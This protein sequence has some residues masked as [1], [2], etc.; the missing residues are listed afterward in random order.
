MGDPYRA[1][2][3][4]YPQ[5]A[6]SIQQHDQQS[7]HLPLSTNPSAPE[8]SLRD[9]PPADA[10]ILL[11]H[12][13]D[14]VVTQ[15]SSLPPGE[16]PHWTILNVR[17]AV[18][19]LSNITY[20]QTL[21]TS[22]A[23]MT[24]LMALLAMSAHHLAH[25]N[26][27]QHMQTASHWRKIGDSAIQHAKAHLQHSLK[28]EV[29]GLNRA[30]YKDQVMAI[31]AMLAFAVRTYLITVSPS[32]AY[33]HQVLYDRQQDARAYVL[34]TERLLRI[35]DLAKQK[36]SRK[37]RMLHHLYTWS[38]IVGE[39]SYV[40]RNHDQS[41]IAAAV[42][43]Y[44]R[45]SQ[46]RRAGHR[47]VETTDPDSR[48]GHNPKLDDFLRLDFDAQEIDVDTNA[49]KESDKG[50]RDIHLEDPREYSETMYLQLYD[51][52]ETWLSLVSQTTRL[53]NVMDSL[54][55]SKKRKYV[56]LFESLERRK[57]RPEHMVC[58]FAATNKSIKRMT[59]Q[60]ASEKDQHYPHVQSEIE[61]PRSCMV[62]AL[63]SALVIFFYRRIRNVRPWILQEHVKS[64]VEA[65][66][67]FDTSCQIVKA[68]GPGCVWPVFMA[69]CEAVAPLQRDYLSQWLE[70]AFSKTGFT[71]FKT[72]V[73]PC[74]VK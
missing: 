57:Q 38:R 14:Q 36:I 41:Q 34:D 6:F 37:A 24:N 2:Q 60:Q 70:R 66:Q 51:I 22:N 65:L 26:S 20:I 35:R 47:S 12:F 17:S 53:A 48:L 11:K 40:L 30:K 52:S 5:H 29:R 4:I 58:S 64:V 73:G 67:D 68:E 62:R 10:Q 1:D 49:Q 33:E 44:S 54:D 18:L 13:N 23:A 50:L 61:T 25:Q 3:F 71:R 63:C 28:N 59:P 32:C 27:S 46:K 16:K 39:S 55:G 15:F 31:S 8:T 45:S 74:G 7:H 19:T 42:G 56:E 9:I 21:C 69:G 43:S 72:N